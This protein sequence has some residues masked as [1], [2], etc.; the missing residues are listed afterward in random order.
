[1]AMLRHHLDE[2]DGLPLEISKVIDETNSENRRRSWPWPSSIKQCSC[3]SRWAI[4]ES[5]LFQ[6]RFVSI[7]AGQTSP[8][9]PYEKCLTATMQDPKVASTLFQLLDKA[10]VIFISSPTGTG[11]S[12]CIPAMCL[13]W[14]RK[15][16]SR[17]KVCCTQP[18]VVAAT[19]LAARAK[20][21]YGAL[22]GYDV[23]FQK[24]G[25][26]HTDIW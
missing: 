18:R 3:N 8:S 23:R 4:F 16:G 19:S 14:L 9:F 7:I 13:H 11:K 22:A 25:D 10:D 17:K 5:L 6:I 26:Y 2:E 12:I 21:Y 15:N 1:M 20:A 24:G